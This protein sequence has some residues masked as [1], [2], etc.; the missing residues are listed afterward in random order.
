MSIIY[1]SQTTYISQPKI[2]AADP[3]TLDRW[4]D[5]L[6]SQGFERQGNRLAVLAD[7]RRGVAS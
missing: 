7:E 4:A 5:I 2:A 3:S 6:V 1:D